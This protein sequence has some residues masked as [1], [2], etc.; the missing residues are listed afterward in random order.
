VPS[1]G[2]EFKALAEL[3]LLHGITRGIPSLFADVKDLYVVPEKRQMIQDI[4]EGI[5]IKLEQGV[6]F[7]SKIKYVPDF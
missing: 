3:Y 7:S 6:T 2:E 5:R 1:E 4:V